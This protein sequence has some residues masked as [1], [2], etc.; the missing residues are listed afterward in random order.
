MATGSAAAAATPSLGLFS[1]WTLLCV[2]ATAGAAVLLLPLARSH[3]AGWATGAGPGSAQQLLD[4]R[5]QQQPQPQPEFRK[6]QLVWYR[7]R[8]GGQAQAKVGEAAC[9]PARLP[10]RLQMRGQAW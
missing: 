9:L 3:M 8:D 5:Q 10:A 4:Q 6:G 1:K 7:Q 2:A